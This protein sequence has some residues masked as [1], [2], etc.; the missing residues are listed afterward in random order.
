MIRSFIQHH[1]YPLLALLVI[2]VFRLILFAIE[3]VQC[4]LPTGNN[5]ILD[6]IYAHTSQIESSYFI[7]SFLLIFSLIFRDHRKT[8]LIPL[9]LG[10]LLLV[11]TKQTWWLLA[12]YPILNALPS[13]RI[14]FETF[15]EESLSRR[16][17]VTRFPLSSFAAAAF[18][19]AF[20]LMSIQIP[21]PHHVRVADVLYMTGVSAIFLAPGLISMVLLFWLTHQLCKRITTNEK[22]YEAGFTAV[23]LLVSFAVFAYYSLIT[24]DSFIRQFQLSHVPFLVSGIL[25]NLLLLMLGRFQFAKS[26]QSQL[27]VLHRGFT[28]R[29]FWLKFLLIF[30]AL[31]SLYAWLIQADQ[32][33]LVEFIYDLANLMVPVISFCLFLGLMSRI[34]EHVWR[35]RLFRLIAIGLL[36]LTI[37]PGGIYRNKNW[38][39]ALELNR[40]PARFISSR[41]RFILEQIGF[42]MNRESSE[43]LMSFKEDID[44]TLKQEK[45]SLEDVFPEPAMPAQDAQLPEFKTLPHI[46]LV[47]ADAV[48]A[49]RLAVYGHGKNNSPFLNEFAEEAVLFKHFYSASSA[50]SQGVASLFTGEYIGNYPL[51]KESGRT[52]LCHSLKSVG[53][54]LLLSSMINTTVYCEDEDPCRM[55]HQL[56]YNGAKDKDWQ[57]IRKGLNADPNRPLFVYFH[58]KGGHDPWTLKDNEKIFGKGRLDLYD[59]LLYKADAEF[60]EIVN[61]IKILGVYDNAIVIFSSDHGIGLGKHLDQASYSGMYNVNTQI[62][63]LIKIPGVAPA[64]V[65]TVH[66]LVDVRPSLEQILGINSHFNTHGVSFVQSLLHPQ[67]MMTRC[68][69]ATSTYKDSYSMQCSSGIKF[70]YERDYD[71]IDVFNSFSDHWEKKSLIDSF[72]ASEFEDLAQPFVRFMAYGRDSYAF[73]N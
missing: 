43:K 68:V 65:E 40:P 13:N 21:F 63:F 1:K 73:L 70:I 33:F 58:L 45:L 52:S 66:S 32:N 72:T 35:H 34:T 17:I 18:L 25:T 69:F 57:M 48:Y 71:Y 60:R 54:E 12:F 62:P 26:F 15:S 14:E 6:W 4:I 56:S 50:T 11:W 31:R 19:T 36:V 7:V 38:T 41:S 44:A 8:H 22:G 27:L 20:A 55:E 3:K 28:D 10:M 51:K 24:F 9:C 67:T 61:Q 47:L 2:Q 37:L 53:Y 23:I 29:F 46:F 16:D 42:D 30:L 5:D 59:A 39:H 49:K 64:R